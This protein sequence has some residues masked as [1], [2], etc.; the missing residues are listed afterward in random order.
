MGTNLDREIHLDIFDVLITIWLVLLGGYLLILSVIQMV[1]SALSVWTLHHRWRGDRKCE[2]NSPVDVAVVI[3]A[4]NEECN[5]PK[6]LLSFYQQTTLPREIIVVD[7]GSTDQTADRARK[8]LSEMPTLRCSMLMIPRAG[9]GIALQVGLAEAQ[10]ALTCLAD[11]DVE[12]DPG[13]L[14]YLERHF[15]NPANMATSAWVWP[16]VQPDRC[17]LVALALALCQV[18]EYA[19]AIL[20]R[21]GWEAIGALSIVEGRLGM[22]RTESLR[23]LKTL[24]CTPAAIDYAITLE[25]Y[26]HAFE[27][28][29]PCHIGIEPRATVWTRI[30][31]TIQAF[32]AQRRRWARGLLSTYV[33]NRGILFK[34]AYGVVG[35]VELPVRIYTSLFPIVELLLWLTCLV[36]SVVQSPWAGIGWSILWVYVM[37]VTIQLFLS[38]GISKYFTVYRWKGWFNWALWAAVP[39][40]AI[41]WEPIKAT[42]SLAGWI[43]VPWKGGQWHTVRHSA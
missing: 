1:I 42:A 4:H 19:R 22:F 16:L 12:I 11:A 27:K 3:A 39:V 30:P 17:G 2:H 28:H 8:Q 25:M 7:D 23:A 40:V 33:I 31:L 18:I 38:L 26:R 21:P 37:Y 10:C 32:F 35:M 9:K 24:G 41:L 13:V 15:S 14:N 36:L 43:K 5:L 6:T 29:L 34:P 20:W